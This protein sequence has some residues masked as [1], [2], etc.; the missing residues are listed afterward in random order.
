MLERMVR[1]VPEEG[2]YNPFMY[3]FTYK[4]GPDGKPFNSLSKDIL[5]FL[6][7]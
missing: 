7:G 6:Y 3:G 5:K 1:D 4:V 2:M